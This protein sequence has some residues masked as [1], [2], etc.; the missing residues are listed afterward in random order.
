MCKK[1]S[2]DSSCSDNK[3][4]CDEKVCAGA[5]VAIAS[6]QAIFG[7]LTTPGTLTAPASLDGPLLLTYFNSI[8]AYLASICDQEAPPFATPVAIT[9]F[10]TFTIPATPI[11]IVPV[12]PVSLPVFGGD[13]AP[14]DGA[15]QL[16]A[17]INASNRL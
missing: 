9:T 14:F 12:L 8:L 6:L 16:A 11:P 1:S 3:K 15:A 10:L 4:S 5:T 2:S 7:Q 13:C 17:L